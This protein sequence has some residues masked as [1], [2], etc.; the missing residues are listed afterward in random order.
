M[1]HSFNLILAQ[2]TTAFYEEL[3]TDWGKGD[4][5]IDKSE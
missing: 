4:R 5:S 3:K 2:F 1:K